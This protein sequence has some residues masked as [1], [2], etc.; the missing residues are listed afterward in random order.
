MAAPALPAAR[1][2]DPVTGIDTHVVLVPSPPGAPVPTPL[3]HPFAGTLTED[4]ADDVLIDGRP[5]ATVGSGA[6]NDPPHVP[7]SPGT[8]FSR[9]PA[10]RATVSA[11]SSTVLIGGR[12]AARAG[13]P[14]R[15]CNDP[16]DA[17]TTAIAAGS[18]TVFVG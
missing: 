7:T 10:N 15:S 13:D 8:S 17:D 1:R 12:A 18:G 4:L 16:V 3:P 9:P 2:D 6:R 11:G 14:A 5:A